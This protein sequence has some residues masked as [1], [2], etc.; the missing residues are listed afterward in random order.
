[1]LYYNPLSTDSN[2]IKKFQKIVPV[3]R[4]TGLSLIES[5]ASTANE[6]V[7]YR[8]LTQKILLELQ[9]KRSSFTD[10]FGI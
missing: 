3:S 9:Y 8:K 10:I 4:K 1:M 5:Q 2:D 6:Q 7:Y